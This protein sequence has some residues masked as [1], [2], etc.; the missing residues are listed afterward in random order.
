MPPASPPPGGSRGDVWTLNIATR[1]IDDVPTTLD[2][3]SPA[4][5]AYA[6]TG[7]GDRGQQ[8]DRCGHRPPAGGRGVR[9][10]R[11]GPPTR[12]ARGTGRVDTG[13]PAGHPRRDV[14]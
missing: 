4:E 7:S 9:G 2:D 10:H 3:A 6:R 13:D 11:G 5:S 12:P 14:S 8:R 1:R